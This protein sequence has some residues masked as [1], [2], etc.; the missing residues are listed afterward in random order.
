MKFDLAAL[1]FFND[2]N[3]PLSTLTKDKQ[4]IVFVD[5]AKKIFEITHPPSSRPDFKNKMYVATFPDGKR[6]LSITEARASFGL[7]TEVLIDFGQ[8]AKGVYAI[9]EM[10][11]DIKA[12]WK[13]N[14][15]VVIET[16]KQCQPY[17]IYRK[18]QTM[19]EI[20]KVEYIE[21]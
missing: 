8:N 9:A 7:Y 13:D 21:K 14:E 11:L 15:T 3:K 5:L 16:K 6:Q 20:V 18:V 4:D 10:N 1:Q 12:Y 19:G 17:K 2:I